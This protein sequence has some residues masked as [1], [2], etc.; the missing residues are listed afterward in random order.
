MKNKND[1]GPAF[2]VIQSGVNDQGVMDEVWSDD[3]MSLRDYLAA[4][5]LTG[6]L[7]DSNVTVKNDEGANK[8]AA[9]CYGVAD[10]MLKERI[11]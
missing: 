8:L 9:S 4:K 10:A 5:A 7:S 2:S 11:K 1:G 6:F 3:G